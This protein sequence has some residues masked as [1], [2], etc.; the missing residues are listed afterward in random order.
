MCV[1]V[2]VRNTPE[3]DSLVVLSTRQYRLL[4]NKYGLSMSLYV[5]KPYLLGK[6]LNYHV[7]R[8]EIL[9][10]HLDEGTR[11]NC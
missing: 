10:C 8:T 1:C 2:Y 11:T 6:G 4:L 3:S 5:L 7:G 9:D